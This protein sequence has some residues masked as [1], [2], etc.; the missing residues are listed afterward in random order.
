MR[1]FLIIPVLALAGAAIASDRPVSRDQIAVEKQLAGRIAGKP[2][3]CLTR[4]E[5]ENMSVHN[6]MLLYRVNRRLTY[7]NEMNGCNQ[8]RVGDL[9]VTRLYGTSQLC[10]GD[11]AEIVSRAGY[12][13][14]GSCAFGDFVPYVKAE[15]TP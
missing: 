4:H 5:A 10:R 8:L 12:F 14:K 11:I 13:P 6:G 15:P 2:K 1:A 3:S 7:K 9:I